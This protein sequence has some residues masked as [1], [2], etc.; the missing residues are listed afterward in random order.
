[1][2]NQ[3]IG[4]GKESDVYLCK[5]MQGNDM[6][7]KLAR[8]GRTSFRSIKNNRDYLRGRTQYSWLY[9]SRLATLKEFLYMQTQNEHGFPTPKPIDSNRHAIQMSK[10]DGLPLVRIKNIVDKPGVYKQAMDMIVKLTQYGLIHCDYNEFNLMLDEQEKLHVIDFPQM[11]SISHYNADMYMMRDVNCIRTLFWRKYNY[12]IKDEQDFSIE[13]FETIKRLDEN[14]QASGYSNKEENKEI[15][16][17]AILDGI[18]EDIK[19]EDAGSEDEEEE[20][21]EEE[22]DEEEEDEEE[23]DEEEGDEEE[24]DEE[25]EMKVEKRI[26]KN[27]AMMDEEEIQESKNTE[28]KMQHFEEF[29]DKKED[30]LIKTAVEKKFKKKLVKRR[31][32]TNNPK[33]K[34]AVE[35]HQVHT[36]YI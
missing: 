20:G 11:V 24:E 22:G 28:E 2:V 12:V 9:L 25:A 16:N 26:K 27:S 21:D 35:K 29:K 36:E 6:V 5:D 32:P 31:K 7:L 19:K 14:V 30:K 1:M 34:R 23:E 4:S 13:D 10:I 3:K 8:L 18:Y 33:K 15:K 17:F